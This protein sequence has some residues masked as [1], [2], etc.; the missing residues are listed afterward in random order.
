MQQEIKL[1]NESS[2]TVFVDDI[3]PSKGIYY[4]FAGD[5]WYIVG[6]DGRMRTQKAKKYDENYYYGVS[7][8]ELISDL[9][10]GEDIE[11]FTLDNKRIVTER[12]VTIDDLKN[13]D[14]VGFVDNK[15]DKGYIVAYDGKFQLISTVGQAISVC[16]Y[17]YG[18]I[19]TNNL[20]DA[21][22]KNSS[23]KSIEKVIKFDTRKE[24]YQWLAE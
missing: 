12:E 22:I 24:L 8:K 3:T 16:N 11:V 9:N 10:K 1:T 13:T 4:M 18:A 7:L 14:H 15:G 20:S 21:I 17:T 23:S 6:E 5:I 2:N 19:P